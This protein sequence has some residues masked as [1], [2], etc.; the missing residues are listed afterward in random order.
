[1]D[2]LK[3]FSKPRLIDKNIIKRI[4]NNN[5]INNTKP[6]FLWT[7]I[8]DYGLIVFIILFISYLIYNRYNSIQIKKNIDKN[9]PI[10]HQPLPQYA[11]QFLQ[12]NTQVNPIVNTQTTFVPQQNQYSV[13]HPVRY[14]RPDKIN[15]INDDPTNI[16]KLL[17][18]KNI[19]PVTDLQ[20]NIKKKENQEFDNVKP[21]NMNQNT[22]YQGDEIV[23]QQYEIEPSHVGHNFA[24]I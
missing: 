5:N 23:K 6:H 1:M 21:I 15:I 7:F 12:N 8:K 2:N 9:V 20:D 19:Q 13:E 11:P 10:I 24:P 17:K 18:D 3:S 16:N 4:I 22:L 14:N